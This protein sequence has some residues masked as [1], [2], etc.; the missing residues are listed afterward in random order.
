MKE[1]DFSVREEDFKVEPIKTLFKLSKELKY[2]K[3]IEL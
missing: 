2:K 1:P 3:N